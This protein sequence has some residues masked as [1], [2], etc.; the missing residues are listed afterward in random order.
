[1]ISQSSSSGTASARESLDPSLMKAEQSNSS[2]LFGNSWILKIYRS[3]GEGLHPELEMMKFL[4]ERTTFGAF[5]PLGGALEYCSAASGQ[6]TLGLLQRF[7]PNEGD[8]WTHTLDAL[9]IYYEEVLA[10]AAK[11]QEPQIP[12]ESL[13]ALAQQEIPAPAKERIGP[14]LISA[15]LLGE[16]LAQLHLAL[17]S[18]RDDPRFAPEPFTELYQRSIYQLMRGA[19]AQSLD[20][21]RRRAPDFPEEIQP[22][23]KRLLAAEDQ[24][25][26]LFH[27]ILR[28]RIT[29]QRIRCHGDFHLGQVLTT[30]KDFILI[31]FEGEPAR[32]FG[33]RRIKRSPLKDVAGMLRSFHYAAYAAL[34]ARDAGSPVRPEDQ[35]RLDSWARYWRVWVSAAFLRS[36]LKVVSQTDLLPKSREELGLLLRAYMMEKA[37]YELRYEMNNRPDWVKIPVRGILQLLDGKS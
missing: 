28:I 35:A 15:Q 21:L 23:I 33:D 12:S 24:V 10:G 4:S 16:R 14:Y 29:G 36:Y 22:E 19:A 3:L 26:A 9:G 11:E 30:G 17:S 31:D 1:M 6:R 34:L 27:E 32:S 8:A 7:V 18:V 2:I 20:L 37:M 5:P 25:L 13:V